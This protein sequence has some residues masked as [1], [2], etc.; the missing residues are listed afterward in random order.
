MEENQSPVSLNIENSIAH[1]SI[2]DGKVNALGIKVVEGLHSALDSANEADIILLSGR[3]GIFSA[4][5]DL[6]V[7]RGD[8]A[9]AKQLMNSGVDLFLK[10]FSYPKPII[11]ACTGHAIAAG[12]ILLMCSDIR[13]GPDDESIKI[14]LNEVSIGMEIPS[15]LVE[16][17]SYRLAK[18]RVYESLALAKLY[19]PSQ[20]LDAGFLDQTVKAETV[21]DAAKSSADE[22]LEYLD[23]TAFQ[24]TKQ[25][26]RQPT[27]DK[28]QKSRSS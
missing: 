14:G 3:A 11:S 2:D 15:F 5:F 20:A 13:I 28:I 17:A 25:R 23:L 7:I 26:L 18:E 1:I 24:K 9:D 12:A 22:I 10:M 21:L 4:G 6:K 27:A 8:G 16:L 19:T